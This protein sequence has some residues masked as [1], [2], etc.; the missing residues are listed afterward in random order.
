MENDDINNLKRPIQE[1][2]QGSLFEVEPDWRSEWWDMPEFTMGDATPQY[3]ITINFMTR[4]DVSDFSNR[5]GLKLSDKSNSAWF[6]QQK[7]D[8]PK[9]WVYVND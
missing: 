1:K 6:P 5:L 4:E 9:E 7:I 3:R 2:K 8:E